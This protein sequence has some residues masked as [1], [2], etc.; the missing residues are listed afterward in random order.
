MLI[1]AN[2]ENTNWNFAMDKKRK[3]NMVS[4][5]I[6][7]QN[8]QKYASL[9]SDDTLKKTIKD[10][11]SELINSIYSLKVYLLYSNFRKLK[12]NLL[13]MNIMNIY[14]RKWK[15]NLEERNHYPMLKLLKSQS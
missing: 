8:K 3:M 2:L 4:R 14:S 13:I 5:S 9:S 1:G 15:E 7:F 12:M 11:A 10:A 6:D